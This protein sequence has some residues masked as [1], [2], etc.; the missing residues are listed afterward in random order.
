MEQK[1]KTHKIHKTIVI[2]DGFVEPI[3]KDEDY[4]FGAERSI[5]NKLGADV[6]I[7][8]SGQ[9][10]EWLP[11]EEIQIKS[12]ET[13]SCVAFG[14]TSQIETH[15]KKV[16][17]GSP[18]YSDRFLV[19]LANIVPPGIDPQV[20][21]ELIRN[22]G[23][24][25]E[26]D[27]PWSDDIKTIEQ[28][29][30]P[31][32]TSLIEK[33]KEFLKKYVFK[34]EYLPRQFN[35]LIS[36]E[37]LKEALKYSPLAVAV[38][39]WNWDGEKYIRRGEDTHWVVLY[40]WNEDGT[41]KIWDSYSPFKKRLA[42]DFGFKWAKR[43]WLYRNLDETTR[44]SILQILQDIT[45]RLLDI[46][47]QVNK[48]AEK[49]E[50]DDKESTPPPPVPPRVSRIR[51][52]ADAIELFESAPEEWNN[53]GAIRGKDGKFLKFATYEQGYNY[54]CDYLTRACTGKHPAYP[55]GGETSLLLFTHIYA[56]SND[57]NNPDAYA[58][59]VA[60]RLKVA[61]AIRIKELL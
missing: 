30:S 27:H 54:L 61:T 52:W 16:F 42:K 22:K 11:S 7:N 56:P 57:G 21:Y 9:W 45:A 31:I 5:K 25:N 8:P 13:F 40:G 18:N 53:P 3:L 50:K 17:G 49:D 12:F 32:P 24:V 34:H 37:T 23:L 19:T 15:E 44:R 58:E 20:I 46:L 33:A 29:K 60:G 6:V 43:I 35:G 26:I 36:D 14:S 39:A 28:Y 10:D 59:F 2:N 48:I 47:F 55:A 38:Q 41:W 51:D 1:H 4:I